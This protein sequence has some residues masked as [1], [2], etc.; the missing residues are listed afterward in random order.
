MKRV[1][2]KAVY[3]NLQIAKEQSHP[4]GECYPFVLI[5][6]VMFNDVI[7]LGL[8]VQAPSILTGVGAIVIASSARYLS[9]SGER[10]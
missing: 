1:V 7:L 10:V 3:S 6:I 4:S 8:P 2:R 5:L 9:G